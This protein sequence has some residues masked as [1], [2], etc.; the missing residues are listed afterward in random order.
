[1]L[2]AAVLATTLAGT[3]LL[4]AAPAQAASSPHASCVGIIVSNLAPAGEFD[5]GSFKALADSE[6]AP[7]FGAFVSTGARLHAST[8]EDCLP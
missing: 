6:G 7:T 5:V 3:T 8:Y 2:R 1:M 4:L